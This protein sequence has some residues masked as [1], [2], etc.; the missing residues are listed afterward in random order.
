MSVGTEN[1][2]THRL[3]GIEALRGIAALAVVLYHFPEALQRMLGFSGPVAQIF[4]NGNLGVDAFFILSGFVIALSLREGPWTS[5]YF[6]RF[7]VRRSIRLDPP[8][9]FAIAFEVFL[10][11]LG[12]RYFGDA[13]YDFP[14]A[15]D[16]GAHLLYLQGILGRMQVS[17]VFWTLCFEIQFYV[18]LVGVVVLAHTEGVRRLVAPK[19]LLGVLLVVVTGLSLAIRGGWVSSPNDGLAI[20]RAYQFTLGITVFLLATGRLPTAPAVVFAAV[21]LVVRLSSGAVAEVVVMGA[22]IASCYAA[23]RLPAFNRAA[24]AAPLQLLGRISYSLYLYHAS[25]VWRVS[26]IAL[27]LEPRFGMGA[28]WAGLIA[29]IVGSIAFA[30]VLNRVL[31]TPMMK[32]SRRVKL[33]A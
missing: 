19:V 3:A 11:W 32:L 24:S 10:G 27:K 16:I 8:Y 12:V 20:I 1:E 23:L 5:R 9:W 30:Y 18:A 17:D 4:R 15:A 7:V 13:A 6:G 31:E 26:T 2:T 33:V 29:G 25:I 14:T 21:V 22:A 28:A